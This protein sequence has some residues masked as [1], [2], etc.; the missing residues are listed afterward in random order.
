MKKII[1][2]FLIAFTTQAMSAVVTPGQIIE[3]IH[4]Q[5]AKNVVHAMAMENAKQSGEWEYII[6]QIATGNSHWLT[7]V[8][9]IAPATD[10][11]FAED[12][13]TALAQAL[14]KNVNG[15]LAI[16]NDYVPPLATR[17]ICAM[18][19]YHETIPEQNA[20]V[21]HAVQALYKSNRV[22]AQK[23]LQQLVTTVGQSGPFREA[24]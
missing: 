13:S 2:V 18:P 3:R 22:Q 21:V 10:A 15:V 1:I 16:I 8:P 20:Y 5:G 14:P 9:L 12:I 11:G 7:L 24:D 4:Q 6:E 19:L 23:C 17:H